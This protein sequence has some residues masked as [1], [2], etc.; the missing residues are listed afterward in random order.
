MASP[1]RVYDATRS[2][3]EDHP[4]TEDALW[5]LYH[6]DADGA[7]TFEDT[8][9]D[10]GRFGTLVSEG[11]VRKGNGHYRFADR[12]AVRAAISGDE[13]V[14]E[15]E[16]DGFEFSLP[17]ID[18]PAAVGLVLALA[19]VVVA[20]SIRYRSVFR[21]G[22]VVSPANDPYFYRHW[23]HELLYLSTS[24]TD[25][26]PITE[27]PSGATTRPLTHAGNWWL[28]T[29]LG[30]TPEAADTVAAWLPVLGTV[31]LAIILY[32]LT[33]RLTRDR[34]IGIVAVI[35]LGIMP[36]H[37]VY[38]GLGFL[39]HRVYQYFFLGVLAWCLV[40]W[41][42]DTER[43]VPTDPDVTMRT[44]LLRPLPWLVMVVFAVSIALSVH[45]W[46]GSALHFIPIGAYFGLKAIL[47]VR[48]DVSPITVNAPAIVGVGLGNYL[49]Y[50]PYTRW[51]W[52]QADT[53][54]IL[55]PALVFAGAICYVAIGEVWTRI[56]LH[57]GGL[58][59]VYG[60]LT[61]IGWWTFQRRFPDHYDRAIARADD[62][63]FREAIAEVMSLFSTDVGVV[64]GPLYQLGLVFYLAVPVALWITYLVYRRYEPGYL[65]LIVFWWY[66]LA[67]AT[68]Q[69]RFAAHLAIFTAIL[70][71]ISLVYLFA[72]IDVLSRPSPF[73]TERYTSQSDDRET[74]AEPKSSNLGDDVTT[75]IAVLA[76]I[77]AIL[78]FANVAVLWGFM[79]QVS[80]DEEFEAALAI[81]E[82]LDA[83][84]DR[85]G[86]T[87]VLSNWGD[88]RLYNFFV[89]KEA[90]SYGYAASH[91]DQFIQ[92]SHPDEA[93]DEYSD[94]VGFVVIEDRPAPLGTTQ[95]NLNLDRGMGDDP[96]TR[97]RL[98]FEKGELKVYELVEGAIVE[99]EAPS[100]EELLV[101]TTVEV[102]GASFEYEA[103]IVA[104]EEGLATIRVPYPGEYI[105]MNQVVTINETAINEGHRVH[106]NV[107]E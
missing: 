90:S 96:A 19:V 88:N 14:V 24:P 102:S 12:E 67:L 78:L 59:P 6:R 62:L 55:A 26:T 27:M 73:D 81:V 107:D 100:G 77:G 39:E 98:I 89:N 92:S 101:S 46:R 36:V 82:H 85:G 70:G 34:R 11:I 8:L 56:D 76:L 35:L 79:D 45:A 58:V 38:T 99:I 57:V 74:N 48:R 86:E 71:A 7:W 63:L 64:F 47:D 94:R 72:W 44:F 105:V 60:T 13:F 93:Y 43:R 87:F 97:Y 33:V 4:D 10:S 91:Y 84:D 18:W 106:V 1:D 25:F 69:I 37:A 2:F 103:T 9:L 53:V 16:D 28:A 21:E 31:P 41:A 61:G 20:R 83:H 3:L 51:G 40:W 15:T 30:G 80:Q 5:A 49:A 75:K 65:V 29:V 54:L 104:N 66:Y 50:Q 68:I 23:Q 95:R 22:Y 52:H 32:F 17:A 42:V